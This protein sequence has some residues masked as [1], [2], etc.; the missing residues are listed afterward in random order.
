MSRALLFFVL[1]AAGPAAAMQFVADPPFLHLSGR[2]ESA[3]WATWEETMERYRGKID[4]IVFHNSP[5]GHSNT[6]RRIA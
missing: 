4:T 5:G 1:L 3:D 6:G 2:V